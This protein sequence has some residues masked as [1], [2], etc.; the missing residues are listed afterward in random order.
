MT[1]SA[2]FSTPP[3]V[4]PELHSVQNP[5]PV[6]PVPAQNT[7]PT[8]VHSGPL[9]E[10]PSNFFP[11]P[12]V[13][14]IRT[15]IK[16]DV[17]RRYLLSHPD[18]NLVEFL[19]DGFNRN[20]VEFL[21][22]GFTFGFS[23]GVLGGSVKG[24]KTKNNR[25]ALQHHK[26][27][28]EAILK[29]LNRGHTAG[30]FDIPPVKDFH[31]SPLG[32][33]PKKDRSIR[34]IL[35]LSSPRGDAVNEFI[36]KSD[37][38]VKYSC[39]DDAADLVFEVGKGC[40]LAKLDIKHAFRLIPVRPCDWKFLGFTFEGR[41]YID[42]VLPMGMRSSPFIFTSFSDVLHWIIRNFILI[43]GLLHYL[44]DFFLCAKTYDE[45]LEAMRVFQAICLE[46]GVPLAPDK[47]EG[48][49][50]TITYLG[51]EIDTIAQVCRL[52]A[53]K[54]TKIVDE[55]NSWRQRSS[56]TKRELLS[57][58]GVLSFATK[59]VKPGRIFLRRLITCS[60]T[61][62][63]L[64]HHIHVSAEI[65]RDL[66]WWRE[67]LHGW[68]GV[69]MIQQPLISSECL[70]LYTDASFLGLGGFFNGFWFSVPIPKE[71]PSYHITFFELLAVIAAVLCW[72]PFLKN[73]QINIFY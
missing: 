33:E 18:R 9:A 2:S 69:S 38:A 40:F 19:L 54:L 64:H 16:V 28:G 44:D 34:L 27:L 20:L 35:D 17:L 3:M 5:I 14:N 58:I 59:V 62:T 29:E 55:L 13:N 51:I 42:L 49:S 6:E 66:A 1:P 61:V 63:S 43:P 26:G 41:F 15:P 60:T 25:S 53:D 31:S 21:L 10:V 22:D 57:L 72:G 48:P 8:H 67:F 50:Q 7:A 4:V 32:A 65:S 52:P 12:S 37:F 36:S 47:I 11:L 45:C 39:F 30:P 23:V 68:N 24:G 46:L 71:F 70:S 73:K 56:V